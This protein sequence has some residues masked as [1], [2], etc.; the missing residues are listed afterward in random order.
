MK[1][2][3]LILCAVACMSFTAK[4]DDVVFCT[5]NSTYIWEDCTEKDSCHSIIEFTI[6]LSAAI[7]RKPSDGE[8]SSI[9][10]ETNRRCSSFSERNTSITRI[11]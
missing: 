11:Q 10:K 4:V 9:L 6:F 8:S 2:V 3:L 7:E 1:K 5:E